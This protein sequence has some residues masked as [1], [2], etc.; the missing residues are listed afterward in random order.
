MPSPFPGMDPY[1]ED[2][3]LWPDVHASLITTIREL[4]APK[5]GPRY[6]ARVEQRAFLFGPD[7]PAGE[8][9]VV[10]DVRI[11]KGLRPGLHASPTSG[12]VA[13]EIAPS[14]DVTGHVEQWAREKFIEIRDA[15]SREVVTIIEVVSPANK[16]N[17][18]EG[19]KSFLKKRD[20][21]HKSGTN[22]LEIDL[23]RTG[24]P[25]ANV[26]LRERLTYRAYVDRT[27][28]EGR[29]QR[30]WQMNLRNRLPVIGV[31]LRPGEPDV[32]L[33]LQ[34]A[35]DLAYD[36]ADYAADTDYGKPP[37]P[38]LDADDARWADELLR[39]KGLIS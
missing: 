27:S 38:P 35:L 8:V 2:P 20:E 33:D 24:A 34:A 36:R 5:V 15:A 18:S 13:V 22:W 26:A 37:K 1:L 23:L 11:V 29:I 9:Y 30:L 14:V 16:M 6:V 7:D 3:E 17:S 4:I 25:T 19:R 32:P 39:S 12:G 10:P 31:P 28:D 21:V